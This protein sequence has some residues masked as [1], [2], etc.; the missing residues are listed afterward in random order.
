[1]EQLRHHA[2][3]ISMVFQNLAPIYEQLGDAFS[4]AKDKVSIAKVDA[5]GQGR[6]L[7]EKYGVTGYPSE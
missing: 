1:M 6:P 3:P 7:G 2:V 4:H 5:D